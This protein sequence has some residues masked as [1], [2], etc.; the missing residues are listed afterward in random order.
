MV[1]LLILF[2]V[3]AFALDDKPHSLYT[4]KSREKYYFRSLNEKMEDILNGD[5]KKSFVIAPESSYNLPQ[6]NYSLSVSSFPP[7]KDLTQWWRS[8]PPPSQMR[9][10]PFLCDAVYLKKTPIFNNSGCQLPH[11]MNPSAPRCQTKYLK[12]ICYAASIGVED[13]KPNHFI[14]P[15]S[16]HHSIDNPP[17]P[18]LLTARHSF[19]TM[20]GQIIGSCGIVHTTA[21]CMATGYRPY[22]TGFKRSCTPPSEL[23]VLWR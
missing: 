14:L 1:L 6:N 2:L 11:Y 20:C 8:F 22:A 18:Y 5:C 7:S 12:W 4:W 17:V 21:N 13:S 23:Q 15:E 10:E 3:A 9:V 16:N 19:V